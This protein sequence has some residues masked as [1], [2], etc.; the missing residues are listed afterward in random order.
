VGQIVNDFP[1]PPTS[2]DSNITPSRPLAIASSQD[3]TTAGDKE[4]AA[5]TTPSRPRV[6]AFSTPEP[7][8]PGALPQDIINFY[9]SI[10][11][12]LSTSFAK[13]APHTV[14]RLAELI[15]E[16]KRRYR[17]LPPYL[18]ALDRVISVTSPNALFPLPP[19]ILPNTHN[20]L[21]G[22][23][24]TPLPAAPLGSDESLG[25]ALLTP[26]PWLQNRGAQNELISES[27]EIVHGPNGA[28]RI[29]TVTVGML[30]GTPPAATSPTSPTTV[31]QIASSH[32]DG[33]TLPSTGAVTQGE[34]LRQEQ[35]AGVVLNNPH[36]ITAHAH[37]PAIGIGMDNENTVMD[38]VE[39]EEEAPHARGPEVIGM[40]DMG[41]QKPAGS[42][43]IEGAVGRPSMGRS[44]KSPGPVADAEP[45]DEEMKDGPTGEDAAKDDEPKKETGDKIEKK[46]DDKTDEK[47]DEEMKTDE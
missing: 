7:T 29:E 42:L 36:S 16:P 2:Q 46:E 38:T 3:S 27:T 24:S 25:G 28:G 18:R 12:A 34:I 47:V 1:K 22:S 32:P 39:P 15:I 35:E 19:A 26:I 41:P 37:R 10:R 6:P 31:A 43:D 14:Q 33:E 21:N 40:E 17:F 44:S 30:N 23:A 5:P 45:K 20:I 13:D 8:L 9:S 11:S 4:N